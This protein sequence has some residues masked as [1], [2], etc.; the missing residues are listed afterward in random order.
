[1][2]DDIERIRVL[3]EAKDKDFARAMERN[4]RLIAR[5]GRQM[6]SDMGR[7]TKAVETDLN[8]MASRSASIM[9]TFAKGLALGA[10][11][12]VFAG[13]STNIRGVV[14]SIAQVGDEARRSG[15]GLEE[16]Q[17]WKYVASQNRIGV[18][19]LVDG[20]K[21][22]SLR[23][24]EFIQTGGGSAA[25]AFQ[26]LGFG[27]GELGKKLK[28]PS[29]LMFEILGRL[30]GFDKAGQIRIADELFGGSGGER[31]VELLGQGSGALRD[32]YDR[33]SEVGAVLDS[34]LIAKAVEIDRKFD[35]LNQRVGQFFKGL[36]VQVADAVVQMSDLRT[37]IED[38]FRSADQGAALMGDG[39]AE[40]LFG[41][42]DAVD[43]HAE[44]LGRLRRVYEGL[45]D[46]SFALANSLAA[47]AST[48]RALGY[49]DVAGEVGQLATEFRE[50]AGK[51]QDGTISSGEFETGLADL[52]TRAGEAYDALDD[53]DRVEFTGVIS[54]IGRIAGALRTAID[55][56][57]SL[58]AAL[59]G[60]A[61]VA[62]GPVYGDESP[63]PL[64]LQW[65][66]APGT[67]RPRSAPS[68]LGFGAPPSG[69]GRRSSG[70]G[71]G[72]SGGAGRDEY[73]QAI[74]RM[75]E[76]VDALNLEASALAAAAVSGREY[77]DAIEFAR[78]KADLLAQAQKAGKTITPELTAEVDALA[79]AYVNAAKSAD[80][81]KFK[82]EE[83]E[84]S[85]KR[86]VDAITDIFM[87]VVSGSQSAGQAIAA[88]LMQMARVQIQKALS[89]LGGTGGGVLSFIGGLL[90]G[91]RA[92]GG[93]VR[94]GVPYLVNENTPNSEV[95][96]P[97]QSGAVLN[98]SQAQAALRGQNGGGG[99]GVLQ[100]LLAPELQAQWLQK[101]GLQSVAIT[102]GATDSMARGTP[103]MMGNIR[104][105]GT[106]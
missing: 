48:L 26:R 29:E 36:T 101:A 3:L 61:P 14:S 42:A 56:A 91:A 76:Q 40:A 5:A 99:G 71:G 97:S 87:G 78:K 66:P 21:E 95:F 105:R 13:V 68:E 65:G 82:L 37:S 83:M 64:D 94:A 18:D 58:R 44:D 80:D 70:V 11:G 51:M 12:A 33:A 49:A 16:F 47:D 90:G 89:G 59:P 106:N 25:E 38:V 62:S 85:A 20:F 22:L 1:M 35:D 31:F 98:V 23:A 75:R 104:A 79:E 69:S 24:D 92:A 30:Q 19:A 77:G 34:E 52:S 7:A 46:Q 2:A 45:G 53:V 43:K 32:T 9:G 100:I 28:N 96:V 6:Q 50:L 81:A 10:A 84:Q 102:R 103:G 8:V 73:A 41:D 57:N 39:V 55:Q 86:G 17:R 88:L 93:P 63:P 15:V 27:A 4:N 74:A 67:P 60:G 54:G 72:R